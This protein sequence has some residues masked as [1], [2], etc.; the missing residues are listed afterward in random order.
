MDLKLDTDRFDEHQAIFIGE[1]IEQIKA[2]LEDA[3]LAGE[4]L[5]EVTGNIAFGVAC[6]IDDTA[7]IKF[8]GT[9]VHPY[10]TFLRGDNEL[11][12]CGGS[13]FTHEYVFGVLDEIFGE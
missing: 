10:L 1:I 4:K 8:D 9:E 3:G 6:A 11:I 2:K 13:S 5:R 7:A 12:H